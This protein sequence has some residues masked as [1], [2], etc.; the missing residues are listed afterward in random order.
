[1]SKEKEE[2]GSAW[3]VG[4]MGPEGKILRSHWRCRTQTRRDEK[5]G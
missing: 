2:R 4:C 5:Y 3:C 1:M